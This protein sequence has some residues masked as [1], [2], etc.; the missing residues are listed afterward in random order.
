M[1]S[2]A[3]TVD[4]TE[5]TAES[6]L[7]V[8]PEFAEQ[9][10]SD[11]QRG[12]MQAERKRVVFVGMARQIGDILPLTIER[13]ERLGSRFAE[14]QAVVVENDSTDE[15]KD[16][17]RAWALRRPEQVLVDCR[18]LGREHLHLFE[19]ERVARYA[20]Y[21]NR[22]KDLAREFAPDADFVIALDLDPWGGWSDD[23]VMHS[24]AML[25]DRATAAGMAST[26]LYRAKTDGGALCWGH[27]DLWALRLYGTRPRF[28]P[29]QPLWLPPPGAAPIRLVSAFGGLMTYKAKAF[30]QG[31]YVSIDGDIEHVGFHRSLRALGW[32]I[33]LNPASR[34][35]MHWLHGIPIPGRD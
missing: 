29:W 4:L 16:V 27:Y 26:S 18:D 34:T 22:Y 35:L 23:G 7:P 33:Y 12:A 17:L 5:Y 24:V 28:E 9:Y 32:D 8:D 19:P 10:V 11:V 1:T 15:T 20:E 30:H 2:H 6:V 3:V 13:L 14:W 31:G 21:R 25:G